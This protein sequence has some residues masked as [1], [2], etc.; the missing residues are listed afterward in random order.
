MKRPTYKLIIFLAIIVCFTGGIVYFFNKNSISYKEMQKNI[1]DLRATQIELVRS[2][3]EQEAII[4]QQNDALKNKDVETKYQ[5]GYLSQKIKEAEI[6][7][8]E[9][10][11]S[12]KD[13]ISNKKS[14]ID[15][16]GIAEKWSP[17]VVYITCRFSYGDTGQVYAVASGSGTAMRFSGWN[18]TVVLTNKHVVLSESKYAPDSC[19]ISFPNLAGSTFVSREKIRTWGQ[20]DLG[21]IDLDNKLDGVQ[22]TLENLVDIFNPASSLCNEKPAVGE[23]V[24]V[25]GYPSIGSTQSVTITKGIISGYE[26]NYFVTD[27]KIDHGN[28]GGAAISTER[29]CFLGIPTAAAVGSIESLGRIL[30]INI[31]FR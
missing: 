21:V 25:L 29:N 3:E 17:Y 7:Q 19:T 31:L 26:G 15:F 18:N 16:T 22:K 10:V 13:S 6:Q 14:P 23:D 24:L 8:E 4:K 1:S 5:I 9:N 28:S 12:L 11:Q 20:F 27:A 30:D 2:K